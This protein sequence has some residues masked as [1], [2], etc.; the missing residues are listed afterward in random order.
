MKH[1]KFVSISNH[2][3]GGQLLPAV[4]GSIIA[5]MIEDSQINSRYKFLDIE[6][7]KNCLTNEEIT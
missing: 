1:I 2:V 7:Q 4:A 5:Y 3:L 6:F